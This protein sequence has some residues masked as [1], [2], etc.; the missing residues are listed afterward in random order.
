M[1]ILVFWCP[2]C[3]FRKVQQLTDNN[4]LSDYYLVLV[5]ITKLNIY[6]IILILYFA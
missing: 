1:I 5:T 2:G 4:L 6:V 3:A